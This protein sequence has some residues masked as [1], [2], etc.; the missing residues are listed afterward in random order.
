M[1]ISTIVKS[2]QFGEP[3]H[4]LKIEILGKSQLYPYYGLAYNNWLVKAFF[5]A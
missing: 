1:N 2:K 4:E 5:V 3:P